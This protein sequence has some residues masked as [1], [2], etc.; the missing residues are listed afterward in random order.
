M[1]R[2]QRS[3]RSAAKRLRQQSAVQNNRQ[4]SQPNGRLQTRITGQLSAARLGLWAAKKTIEKAIFCIDNVD[5]AC[6]EDDNTHLC[7]QSRC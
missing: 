1:V 4:V 5:L 6:N 3:V 7:L 2:S